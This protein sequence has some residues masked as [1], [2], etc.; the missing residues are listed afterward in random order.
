MVYLQLKK[1]GEYLTNQIIQNIKDYITEEK[2]QLLDEAECVN[3]V[4]RMNILIGDEMSYLGSF[5]N[6]DLYET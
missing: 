4:D 3:I 5:D 2:S 1:G 6:L